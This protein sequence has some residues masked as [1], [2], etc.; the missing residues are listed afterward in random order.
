MRRDIPEAGT[1]L[2]WN[3]LLNPCLFLA[4]AIEA[5]PRVPAAIGGQNSWRANPRSAPSS[6]TFEGVLG[7]SGTAINKPSAE[8]VV[9]GAAASPAVTQ[10]RERN[11]SGILPSTGGGP[12][13]GKGRWRAAAQEREAADREAG[14]RVSIGPNLAGHSI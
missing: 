2:A 10:W 5:S 4:T 6:G 8:N 14:D 11:D 7:F 9:D 12:G 3:M 1:S 13:W